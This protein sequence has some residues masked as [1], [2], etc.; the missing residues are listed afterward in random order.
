MSVTVSK[1]D[2][3]ELMMLEN[4][5][6]EDLINKYTHLSGVH[7]DHNDTK[8][9]LSIYLVLGAS[10]YARV[11]MT[12]SPKIAPSGQPITEKTTLGWTIMSPVRE[13]EAST[14][15]LTQAS[16]MGLEELSQI[17]I[18]GLTDS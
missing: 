14:T 16:S 3:L 11:K 18:P 5:K 6:Y 10:E 9:E 15:F 1:V 8:P 12:T 2:K 7:M 4:P 13:H 17:E